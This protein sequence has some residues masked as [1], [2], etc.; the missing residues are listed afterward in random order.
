[1][2]NRV[3]YNGT[4][5]SEFAPGS[6]VPKATLT[7]L[8]DPEA[9]AFDSSGNLFVA[10]AANG[11]GTTVSEFARRPAAGGVVIR[12]ALSTQTMSIGGNAS[13]ANVNL[14]NA[15]LAQ[16]VTTATGFITFGG[17]TQTGTITFQNA[18]PAATPGASVVV[19]QAATGTGQI[20]LDD[21]SG[22]ALS[23]GSGSVT[24]NAG[25][26]GITASGTNST[27][28]IASARVVTLNTTGAI[29]S[30]AN[31]L[32][33]DGTS[34]PSKVIIGSSQQPTSVFLE[35]LGN[36][37]LG[38]VTSTGAQ[39]YKSL[40]GY[41]LVNTTLTTTNSNITFAS[42]VVL[43]ATVNMVVGTGTVQ[44]LS[45][46]AL[47]VRIN[48]TT[49]NTYTQM[50]VTGSVNLDADSGLV[51]SCTSPSAMTRRSATPIH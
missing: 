28:D 18:T 22:I 38:T 35:G 51:R 12:P 14:T 9:L 16:I 2:A 13:G 6:T 11:G 20:V 4:T 46:S 50:N 42:P 19:Q 45:T 27:A 40:K 1:M 23:V 37:N 21:S 3:N 34:T 39:N 10:N 7:G 43:G 30:A 26:N 47:T 29:G 36:I 17:T 5:V 33:L 44:M 15:E 32:I 48:G 24:L 49:T 41:V 25:K 8:N 31:P